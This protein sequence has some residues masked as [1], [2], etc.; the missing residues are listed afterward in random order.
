ME[1]ERATTFYFAFQAHLQWCTA[2]GS[3]F[4]KSRTLLHT[5]PFCLWVR[6]PLN[7]SNDEQTHSSTFLLSNSFHMLL[8]K[9]NC[10]NFS[11]PKSRVVVYINI[12]IIRDRFEPFRVYRLW[13]RIQSLSFRVLN[14]W[15]IYWMKTNNP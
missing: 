11:E 15:I 10:H 9:R 2:F 4:K 12:Y 6:F 8:M 3:I 13:T 1:I 7:I 5:F 14:V